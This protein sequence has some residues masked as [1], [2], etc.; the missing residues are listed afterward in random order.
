MD[1]IKVMGLSELTSEKR[2][3]GRGKG[4]RT[5]SLG[6]LGVNGPSKGDGERVAGGLLGSVVPGKNDQVF[7]HNWKN[8]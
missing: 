7:P 4:A 5:D 6:T 3:D 2:V 8:I 1:A